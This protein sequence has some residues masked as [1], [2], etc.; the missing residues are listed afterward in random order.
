M[1]SIP[2]TENDVSQSLGDSCRS[3]TKQSKVA[4]CTGNNKK[5][6]GVKPC[7]AQG[8]VS[9]AQDLEIKNALKIL[10]NLQVENLDE[11]YIHCNIDAYVCNL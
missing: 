5:S 2:F 4:H 6:N 9:W 3:P 1:N 8:I 10:K 7:G 11:A